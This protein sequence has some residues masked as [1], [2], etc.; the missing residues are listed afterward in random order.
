M[1]YVK[2]NNGVKMP[3]LGFGVFQVTDLGECERS[4][5]DAISTGYRLIDTAQ[6]YGN[7]EA[8]G[9]AIKKAGVARE[10]LFITT[11]LWIQ[12]NGYEGTR[13][14]FESSLKKLQLDYLD[15]YLIHQPL[16]DVYGE[17]RAM[18]ELYKAGKVRAIGVSNFHPDRLIDLIVHNEI[19]PAVNQIETH[20]FHQ[21][22]ETQ[23]YLQENNVQIESWGPF[24]EGKNNLFQNELLGSIGKK[25]NK[26]IAQVVLRWLTQRGI[27]AIPKSV[28][29]ERMA[30]NINV[31]D[32]ELSADDM[33]SIKALDTA[34]SAFFDHRDPAMVKWLSSFK[35][36]H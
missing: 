15:L 20:P 24:A 23:K 19:V 28:R 27:V 4:V 18:E 8:V 25:Y 34:S 13:K 22:I 14:A 7:E 1:Q 35:I 31:F 9:N 33:D 11:K 3:I 21:Q 12:S 6:S 32:F 30:E 36:N 17:W 16:G 2:L 26:T 10:E 29:K 5:I